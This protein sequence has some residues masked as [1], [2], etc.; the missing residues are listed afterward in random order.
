MAQLQVNLIEGKNFKQKDTFSQ[1]DS[2]VQIYLDEKRH[3]QKSRV[4]RNTNNPT[5]NQTFVL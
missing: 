4:Q 5:W 3:K 1:N 2:Y